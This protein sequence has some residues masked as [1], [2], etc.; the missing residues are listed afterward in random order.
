MLN[1]EAGLTYTVA[2]KEVRV[3]RPEPILANLDIVPFDR[4]MDPQIAIDAIL[5][6]YFVL[7]VDV[8]SSGLSLLKVFLLIIQ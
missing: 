2:G 6:G 1:Q 4:Q 3:D 8:Y 5:E 7:I